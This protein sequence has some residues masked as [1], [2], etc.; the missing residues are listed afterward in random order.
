MGGQKMPQTVLDMMKPTLTVSADKVTSR[1]EG[2]G[3]REFLGLAVKSGLISPEAATIAEKGGEGIYHLDASKSPKTID[4][5]TLG[6]AR[7]TAIGIYTLDGDTLKMCLSIDPVKVAE[8]PKEFTTKAGDMRVI[9][10]LKRQP[11][12][13]P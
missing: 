12:P 9:V 11:T 5:A 7:K 3:A 13:K 1:A 10:T 2:D 6:G 4:F 8:R